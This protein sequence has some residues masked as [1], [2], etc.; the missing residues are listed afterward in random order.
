MFMEQT[1]YKLIIVVLIT[2]MVAAASACATK[3]QTARVLRDV[4]SFG[5]LILQR[6][7]V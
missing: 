1:M 7:E 5:R 2:I 6:L 3:R 4:G